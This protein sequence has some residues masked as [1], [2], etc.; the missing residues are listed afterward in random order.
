[1][2]GLLGNNID[3]LQPANDLRDE[4]IIILSGHIPP[5]FYAI[6]KFLYKDIMHGFLME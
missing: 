2:V 1:M 4:T 3:S 5:V 6:L